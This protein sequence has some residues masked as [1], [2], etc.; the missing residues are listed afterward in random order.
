MENMRFQESAECCDSFARTVVRGRLS[1]IVRG[2][3]VR[4]GKCP[5]E[6]VRG[7][8]S[9]SRVRDVRYTPL[10]DLLV[11]GYNPREDNSPRK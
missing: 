4:E 10:A 5:A 2:Q 6:Y 9:R 8:M 7:D 1:Q 3:I 11:T